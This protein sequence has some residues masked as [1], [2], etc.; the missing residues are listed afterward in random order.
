MSTSVLICVHRGTNA[1]QTPFSMVADAGR[2]RLGAGRAHAAALNPAL[3]EAAKRE[4][5]VVV[6]SA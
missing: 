1:D 5:K 6:Y 3:V 4:G 2:I